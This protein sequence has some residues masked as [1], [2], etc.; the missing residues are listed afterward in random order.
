MILVTAI[1]SFAL[2]A[3]DVPRKPND[4]R[5]R[6]YPRDD[7]GYYRNPEKAA[8]W[9]G[10]NEAQLTPEAR[11]AHVSGIVIL[12]VAINTEGVPTHYLVLKP[13]PFGLTEAAVKAVRTWR[14]DP[15]M[16]RGRVVPVIQ[17]VT[18]TFRPDM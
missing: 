2:M 7:H 10:G 16:D 3:Q 4:F 18:V 9:I 14:F 1:T 5:Y 12:E 17:N 8:K 13:L 15:A 6:I 11:K